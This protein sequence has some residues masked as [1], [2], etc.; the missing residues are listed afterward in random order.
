MKR[1]LVLAHREELIYQAVQHARNA[2]LTAGMEMERHRARD[3]DVVVSTVQT[4]NACR[5]GVPRMQKFDPFEFGLVITDEAHHA[6]AHSYR[7]VYYHFAQN[8]QLRFLGVTA[9]PIRADGVGLHNVFESVSYQMELRDAI[10]LGWLCPIR[11]S[12]V[13]VESLDLSKVRTKMGGDLRDGDLE[14]AFLGNGD[15]DEEEM[16]HRIAKPTI[17]LAAGQPGIIFAAGCEHAEKLTAA[18]NAYEGVYAEVILGETDSE[19]RRGVVKRFR[20]GETQFLVNVGVA[21]EGFDAPAA[22]VVAIARPTK[23]VSLYMQMIGR[24]TRPLPGVVDGPPTP[25]ERRAAIANSAKPICHVLDFVG[26]S[27]EHKLVSVADVLAGDDSDPLIIKEAVEAAKKEGE[28]VDMEALMEKARQAREEKIAREEEER[29]Q[30]KSTEHY[31]E[32][33]S[34]SV[35]DVDIFDGQRRPFDAFN[36]YVP[37]PNGATQ[38]QVNYLIKLGVEPQVAT[39][40][41]SRQARAVIDSLQKKQVGGEFRMPFGKYAGVKLSELPRGYYE[42]LKNSPIAERFSE[43]I[44]RFEQQKHGS[45]TSEF[46]PF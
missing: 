28:P 37:P 4:L 15:I 25:E 16:L 42:W 43:H 5:R 41:S 33:A 40:Y 20:E 30:R 3:E 22:T 14:R 29:R 10:E 38:K 35:V 17:D 44:E 31:A 26:N 32:R 9:T 8:P 21:T 6:T 34:V 23:S 11:Q 7:T 19:I 13:A 27:G 36:D 24:G 12:F 2:G 45:E 1:I 39:K 46:V 18:F